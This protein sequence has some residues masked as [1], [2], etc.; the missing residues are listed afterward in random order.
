M[1]SRITIV[2][3]TT[4]SFAQLDLRIFALLYIVYHTL[5]HF[6]FQFRNIQ[7]NPDDDLFGRLNN[8]VPDV[9]FKVLLR[10][11]FGVLNILVDLIID[12]L[13]VILQ[14]LTT[15]PDTN[16]IRNEGTEDEVRDPLPSYNVSLSLIKAPFVLIHS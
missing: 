9:I 1:V 16:S 4:N 12:I 13:R 11:A 8:V 7:V 3:G 15:E 6:V 14:L 2:A 5:L 10:S